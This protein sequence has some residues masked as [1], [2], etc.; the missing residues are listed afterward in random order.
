MITLR[1]RCEGRDPE[2]LPSCPSG[3]RDPLEQGGVQAP[4]FL[5]RT[6]RG[7]VRPKTLADRGPRLGLGRIRQAEVDGAP[8]VGSFDSDA[9]ECLHL[10]GVV[11]TGD[12]CELD[13]PVSVACPQT[14]FSSRLPQP[15]ATVLAKRFEEPEAVR[16]LVV[17][18]LQDGLLDERPD[19]VGDLLGL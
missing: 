16:A 8:E 18:S 10:S 14:L 7:P 1:C 4:D 15:L 3:S 12:V 13:D 5:G 9:L 6:L 17:L 19:E 2:E 11:G